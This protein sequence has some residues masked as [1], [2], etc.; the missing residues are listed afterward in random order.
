MTEHTRYVIPA[1]GKLW[2]GT[3]DWAWPVL[4]AG[5][6]LWYIPHGLQKLF[7]LWGGN[8][9]GVAKAIESIGWHPPLFWAYYLG[10]LELFGGALLVLGLFTR[11]VAALFAGFMLIATLQFNIRFGYFWTKG[12]IEMT[13]ILLLIAL[14][15]M[16]RGGAERSLDRRLG[17][18]I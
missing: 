17:R 1:L 5:Y 2:E 4:R 16:V 12:G 9:N 7:G 18:E 14:V 6:G 8:I 10:C 15:I 11:P 13:L 3:G